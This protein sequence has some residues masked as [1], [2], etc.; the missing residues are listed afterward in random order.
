MGVKRQGLVLCPVEGAG[1]V[2]FGSGAGA[3]SVVGSVVEVIADGHSGAGSDTE[4]E[5]VSE[6]ERE[7][8]LTE[9]SEGEEA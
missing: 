2:P 8:P 4:L 7:D 3:A 1:V 5:A 6:S 9:P